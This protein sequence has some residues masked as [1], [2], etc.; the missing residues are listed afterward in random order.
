MITQDQI[1]ELS[2][3]YKIADS[4]VVREFIQILF[5]KELYKEK[6]S[7]DIFFKGGTAIRLIHGGKRFSEDLDFTVV[8]GKKLFIESISNLFNK[9]ES[10]YPFSFKEKRTIAGKSYLLTANIPFLK[11]SIYVKLDFSMRESVLQPVKNILDTK[12]PVIIQSFVHSLSKDEILSE[13]IRAI[14]NRNKHRD[15][16]DLWILQELGGKFDKKLIEKKLLYYGEKFEP[17]I[18]RKRLKQFS[19]DQFVKDLRPFVPIN[20]RENL[21]DLFDFVIAYLEKSLNKIDR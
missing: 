16:Y 9:L 8:M 2:K 3:E 19:K 17:E 15:L 5:L 10:E 13:K 21:N 4:I 6:F 12:Y 20:E 14:L 1:K 7:K 11:N 18:V